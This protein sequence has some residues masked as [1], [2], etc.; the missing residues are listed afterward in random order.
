MEIIGDSLDDILIEAYKKLQSLGVPNEG[1]RGDHRELIGVS[2]RIGHPRARLSRSNDR[3]LPFSALGEFL[4]YL[5]KSD[6]IDFITAYIPNYKKEIGPDGR[7]NGAYG[8]RLFST[9]GLDQIEAVI[10]LLE[11]KPHTRRAVLQLYAAKDLKI[12]AEVPCTTTLQ[13]FI[14]D[15]KLHLMAS[16]RSNDAYLGLPH[17]VFCFTMLQ[18]MIANRLG[19]GLGEYIQMVGSFHLYEEHEENASRYTQEGHHRLVEMPPMPAGDPFA[20]VDKILEAEQQ[21]RTGSGDPTELMSLLPPYWADLL[22]L[23]QARFADHPDKIDAI[24]SGL[25]DPLFQTYIDDRRD[26]QSAKLERAAAKN[27]GMSE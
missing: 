3:G 8:P 4:W 22:R 6:D 24:R 7:I 14:R 21:I 26:K 19:V 18:E 23:V 1:S 27:Q 13:F 15:E 12:D 17:D 2:I 11:R 16:L 9:Y 25:T 20:L 10:D 5:T